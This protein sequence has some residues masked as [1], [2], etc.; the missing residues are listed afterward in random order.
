MLET[1]SDLIPSV[2]TVLHFL[3]KHF[4]VSNKKV[5]FEDII[6]DKG[7]HVGKRIRESSKLKGN[8]E[9][10]YKSSTPRVISSANVYSCDFGCGFKGSFDNVSE[11]E[12][13]CKAQPGVLCSSFDV[14]QSGPVIGSPAIIPSRQSF[15]RSQV[16]TCPPE[17]CGIGLQFQMDQFKNYTGVYAACA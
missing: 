8:M 7:S 15:S 11:H 17:N 1:G 5:L 2:T 14:S 4:W 9:R 3:L 12:A 16:D 10:H 13:S 6:Q